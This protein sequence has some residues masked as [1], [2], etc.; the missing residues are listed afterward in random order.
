MSRRLLRVYFDRKTTYKTVPI[1]ATTTANDLQKIISKRLP[2]EQAKDYIIVLLTRRRPDW[3]TL[4]TRVP[5]ASITSEDGRAAASRSLSN[6]LRRNWDGV[7]VLRQD[8]N[9]MELIE[10]DRRLRWPE[11]S[12]LIDADSSGNNQGFDNSDYLMF[13][14]K[15]SRIP[16]DVGCEFCGSSGEEENNEEDDEQEYEIDNEQ[17]EEDEEEE[18]EAVNKDNQQKEQ[19]NNT[20]ASHHGSSTNVVHLRQ[21]QTSGP[22]TGSSESER[23]VL[24]LP[25]DPSKRLPYQKRRPSNWKPLI[26]N[27]SP[28][29]LLDIETYGVQDN[30]LATETSSMTANTF[31]GYL[32]RR[33][34]N[35]ALVWYRRWCVV[36]ND[37]L[38]CCKAKHNQRHIIKIP[39]DHSVDVSL[40]ESAHVNRSMR[41]CFEVKTNRRVYMFR[42]RDSN[43]RDRWMRVLQSHIQVA[44]QNERFRVAEV[45]VGEQEYRSSQ[46]DESRLERVTSSLTCLLKDE[47]ARQIFDKYLCKY[48]CQEGLWFYYDVEHWRMAAEQ[49]N[50]DMNLDEIEVNQMKDGQKNAKSSVQ[51]D[52]LSNSIGSTDAKDTYDTKDTTGTGTSYRIGSGRF[53]G[54]V[55]M[56]WEQ[57]EMRREQQSLKARAI[58][59]LERAKDIYDTFMNSTTAQHEV[60]L[61]RHE[62]EKVKQILKIFQEQLGENRNFSKI[63]LPGEYESD[64]YKSDAVS[65]YSCNYR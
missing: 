53:E 52:A 34:Q 29:D 35:E 40:S 28:E 31:S 20:V 61:G 17:D 6:Q 12:E 21:M 7:H 22:C 18:E 27:W 33:S 8:Q 47:G 43:E 65:K 56:L 14:F 63:E 37:T 36:Q 51:L 5:S 41:Y 60:L 48:H 45:I 24:G 38:W 46:L 57:R 25:L 62:K 15:N 26:P 42:A 64:E 16:L 59:L 9:L 3:H 19:N 23:F 58:E 13:V 49:L 11:K 2:P 30:G 55:S 39:L 1:D 50:T 10:E 4:Q 54:S 32:L 44:V